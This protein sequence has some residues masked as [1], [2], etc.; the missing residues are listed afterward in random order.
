[1]R[2]STRGLRSLSWPFIICFVVVWNALNLLAVWLNGEWGVYRDPRALIVLAVTCLSTSLLSFGIVFVPGM[3]N[4][5]TA[6]RRLQYYEPVPFLFIGAAAGLMG[7]LI[8]IDV[9]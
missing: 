8:L 1:M 6:E 4:L 2:I 7:A 5:V 3:R 9:V